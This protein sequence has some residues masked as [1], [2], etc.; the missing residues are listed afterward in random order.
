MPCGWATSAS[1]AKVSGQYHLFS[2]QILLAT[3]FK[4]FKSD[5]PTAAGESTTQVARGK[6]APVDEIPRLRGSGKIC[7]ISL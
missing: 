5:T 7:F 3:Y 2:D 4:P 6:G 1:S